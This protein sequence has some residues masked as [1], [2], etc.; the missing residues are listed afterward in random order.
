MDLVANAFSDVSAVGRKLKLAQLLDGEGSA[1]G[2]TALSEVG[3]AG[4]GFTIWWAIS[5]P[6]L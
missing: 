4:A 5:G 1:R 2:S 6:C 3:G